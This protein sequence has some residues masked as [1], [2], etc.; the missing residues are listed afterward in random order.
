MR[1]QMG[2]GRVLECFFWV[3]HSEEFRDGDVRVGVALR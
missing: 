1:G 2:K 3:W